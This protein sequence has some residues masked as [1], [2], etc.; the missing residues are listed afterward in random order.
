MISHNLNLILI[1]IVIGG[2]LFLRASSSAETCNRKCGGLTLS[3][4]FGFSPGCPIQLNCSAEDHGAKIGEFSV[5][6]VT[7]N[8]IL[9]GVPSNCTRKIEDMTPLFG[10]HYAPTSENNFLRPRLVCH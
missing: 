2:S 8:S 6:N 1:I 5:R 7:E 9:V 10:T 3:Y 4:P